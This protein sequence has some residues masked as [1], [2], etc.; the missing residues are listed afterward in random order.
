LGKKQEVD[1]CPVAKAAGQFSF[2]FPVFQIPVRF[3]RLESPE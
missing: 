1:N 2:F 3:V